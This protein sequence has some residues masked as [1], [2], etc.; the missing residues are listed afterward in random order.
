M[1][2][3][4]LRLGAL[5]LSSALLSGCEF[6][7][8]DFASIQSALDPQ[9]PVAAAQMSLLT[10]TLW[11]GLLVMA[12]VVGALAYA[13]IRFRRKPGD[14][15]IP[16]QTH[17]N[18]RVE[19]GLIIIAFVITVA[20]I[21]PAIRV[22]FKTGIRVEPT[23]E[24]TVINVT[25]YQWWW[26]FEYPEHGVTTANEIHIPQ[27]GRVI[28]NLTS[29]DVLHS[30]WVPKLAG[31][32]DLIPNQDNQLWFTTTE[33]TPTGMYYGECAELCLGA[34]AYMRMRVIVDTPEDYQAWLESFQEIPTLTQISQEQTPLDP[35]AAQGQQLFKT[36]GC[37]ACHAVRG[38]AGGAPDKPNLTNFGKR[39]YLAAGVLKN[40]PENL[41]RWLRN[42]QAVKPG[43]Y[44]PTLW[45]ADDENR[46][47][48]ISALVAYLHSLGADN[49]EQAMTGGSYGN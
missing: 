2:P 35:L 9:A 18:A 32:R 43:N 12:G 42:P 38:Y 17:G 47:D 5:L 44:M 19:F 8:T 23:P 45:R 31:K 36:K 33:D 7:S 49:T 27:G 14:D 20:V 11:W 40:T 28:L 34:H 26:N 15:A 13:V 48:E 6:A 30:F 3:K 25:G 4:K 22:N 46:E 24:D 21:V 29:A 16:A 1:T 39:K 37:A 41:A 10:Y